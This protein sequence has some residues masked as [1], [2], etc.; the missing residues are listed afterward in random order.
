[1]TKNSREIQI[2]PNCGWKIQGP[3]Y[4]PS[5]AMMGQL[6]G[7]DY[8]P[9][10]GRFLCPQC[11]FSGL[12]IIVKDDEYDQITFENKTIYVPLARSNP[13]YWQMILLSCALVFFGSIFLFMIVGQASIIFGMA[14][15]LYTLLRVPKYRK[16]PK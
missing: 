9:V 10:A 4:L 1:M 16:K 13:L 6:I 8:D 14:L 7:L 12:P 15:L 5:V 3:E 11:N 2:C